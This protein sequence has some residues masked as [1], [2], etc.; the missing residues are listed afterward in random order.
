MKKTT[1]Y[2]PDD[3]RDAIK[4]VARERATSEADLIRTAIRHEIDGAPPEQRAR[5]ERHAR[6]MA[7]LGTVGPEV[8]PP[9][10][11]EELRAGWRG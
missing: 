2:L 9:G 3:L 10:Y 5:A 6:L 11:L 4:R 8:Y 7:V 1:L